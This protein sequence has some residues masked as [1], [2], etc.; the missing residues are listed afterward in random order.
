MGSYTPESM[1]QDAV[2][3]PIYTLLIPLLVE[4]NRAY[5]Y[6]NYEIYFRTLRSLFRH[7]APRI[8]SE[9][10]KNEIRDSLD[11]IE[12]LIL[13]S[14]D[15]KYEQRIYIENHLLDIIKIL[16]NIDEKLMFI[17]DT[18]FYEERKSMTLDGDGNVFEDIAQ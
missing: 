10:E 2:A 16:E 15:G 14:P 6:K 17:I 8:K 18:I 9:K 4:K 7:L 13:N 5:V 11:K 12:K 3:T 1:R